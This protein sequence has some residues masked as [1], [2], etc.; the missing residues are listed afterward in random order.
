MAKHTNITP[1]WGEIG[2]IVARLIYSQE[3]E[4]LMALQN[5]IKRA[6]ALAQVGTEFMQRLKTESN[7]G[8]MDAVSAGRE[9]DAYMDMLRCELLTQGFDT[10]AS[11]KS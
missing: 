11:D 3:W 1:T 8:T 4:V 6:F 5:E 10:N 7:A 2:N 9:F